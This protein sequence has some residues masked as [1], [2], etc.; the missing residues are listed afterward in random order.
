MLS[1]CTYQ[2]LKF[3]PELD[4]GPGLFAYVKNL[5]QITPDPQYYCI[6]RNAA[7]L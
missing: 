6:V 4:P 7:P 5:Q 2:S 3:G 1:I